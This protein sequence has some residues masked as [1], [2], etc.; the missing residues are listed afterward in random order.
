[1]HKYATH[2]IIHRWDCI[3]DYIDSCAVM[4][5][6]PKRFPCFLKISHFKWQVSTQCL[7]ATWEEFRPEEMV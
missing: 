4:P 3:S 7:Y 2:D 5:E 1:M 6:A